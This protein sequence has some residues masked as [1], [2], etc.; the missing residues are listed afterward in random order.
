MG[1]E[2]D[3]K[4]RMLALGLAMALIG[5]WPVAETQAQTAGLP[6]VDRVIREWEDKKLTAEAALTQIDAIIHAMPAESRPA[7]LKTVDKVIHEWED[8]KKNTTPS[9]QAKLTTEAAMK[10]IET[11]VHSAKM[12][13]GAATAT[14]AAA[15]PAQ[16]AASPVLPK[17]GNAGLGDAPPLSTPMAIG[18][19]SLLLTLVAFARRTT[20]SAR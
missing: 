3:M 20:R 2:N 5:L 19:A 8:G 14:A 4:Q 10:E 17:T 9:M 18:G 6:A 13:A 15:A 11:L 16:S 12:T 1:S 7:V